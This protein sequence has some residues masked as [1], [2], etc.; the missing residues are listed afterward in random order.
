MAAAIVMSIAGPAAAA[1]DSA[2]DR[3]GRAMA[4][5][6]A[7]KVDNFTEAS[8]A[9]KVAIQANAPSARVTAAGKSVSLSLETST[10]AAAD[11]DGSAKVFG[12]VARDTDALVRPTGSGVQILSIM[13]SSSAPSKQRYKVQLPDGAKLQASGSGFD[14]VNAEGKSTGSIEAPWAKDATGREL[15]T[16]YT[17]SGNTLVQ[18]TETE[19][20]VF[21]VVADP[22]LTYGLGVYLNMWGWEVR[23]YAITIIALGGVAFVTS[24]TAIGYIPNPALKTLA[25]LICG[26]ASV[27]LTKVWKAIVDTYYAT[28]INNNACYQQKILPSTA[29]SLKVVGSSNC[30]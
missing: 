1:P 14:I 11:S 9:T 20:A 19:G 2:A 27:N 8:K 6:G 15:P 21:P 3:V 7:S 16:R 5:S 18:E 24:C 29:S 30:S 13:N 28:N 22:K 26:A 10:I 23:G 4:V 17:L 12:D 25:T